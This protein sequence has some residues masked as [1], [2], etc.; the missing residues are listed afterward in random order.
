MQV[1]PLQDIEIVNL[2]RVGFNLKNFDM[3]IV[4]K[5]CARACVRAWGCSHANTGVLAAPVLGRATSCACSCVRTSPLP[6]HT[7][8]PPPRTRTPHPTPGLHARRDED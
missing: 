5:V 3:A 8:P 1:V 6:L 2:E 7:C 4:F